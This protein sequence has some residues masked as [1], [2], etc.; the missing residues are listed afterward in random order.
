MN[1]IKAAAVM[2][3]ALIAGIVPLALFNIHQQNV[4]KE[5]QAYVQHLKLQ[6]E[7]YECLDDTL[8]ITLNWVQTDK[9]KTYYDT[10][11]KIITDNRLIIAYERAVQRCESIKEGK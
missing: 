4:E 8:K 6:N 5:N 7:Y 1:R 9:T 3:A 10:N 2:T 11:G